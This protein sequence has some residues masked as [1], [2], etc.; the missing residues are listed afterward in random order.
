MRGISDKKSCAPQVL[1]LFLFLFGFGGMLWAKPAALTVGKT[2]KAYK[3]SDG[4][5]VTIVP[6]LPRDSAQVLI[7][8]SGVDHA[9]DGLVFLHSVRKT[10]SKTD[11]VMPVN[12]R[13]FVTVTVR[14]NQYTLYLTGGKELVLTYDGDVS[15]KVDVNAV[16]DEYLKQP[17]DHAEKDQ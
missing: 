11:Y 14:N 17:D 16:R 10:G 3:G 12:G 6:V 5:T 1:A 7:K 4:V 13:D 9:W 2:A 8:I 15:A